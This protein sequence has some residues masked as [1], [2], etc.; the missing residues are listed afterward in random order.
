[1][2]SAARKESASASRKLDGKEATVL[3]CSGNLS[4]GKTT[5]A[6]SLAKHLGIRERI[7]SPTFVIQKT[8]KLPL[9]AKKKFGFSHFVH[10]DAYRLDNEKELK[11]LHFKEIA[12]DPGNLVLIEWGE[13]V[14][15][16]L[17]ASYRAL[18]FIFINETTRQISLTK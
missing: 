5:F 4:A 17:P 11:V 6:Q 7:T 9:S 13:R 12:E 3:V 16:I 8:Y 10:I 18:H 15:K 1:M 14:K 2:L